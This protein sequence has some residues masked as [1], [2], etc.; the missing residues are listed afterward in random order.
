VCTVA[1]GAVC[2]GEKA[3]SEGML[4]IKDCT[5]SVISQ[6]Y[7]FRRTWGHLVPEIICSWL[8]DQR[9]EVLPVG[10]VPCVCFGTLQSAV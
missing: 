5:N 3:I 6:H 1:D 10:V 4:L 2:I 9:S 8:I 7:T